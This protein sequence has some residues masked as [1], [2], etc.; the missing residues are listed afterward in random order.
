MIDDP[1]IAPHSSIIWILEYVSS[2]ASQK[3]QCQVCEIGEKQTTS[4]T[5]GFEYSSLYVS[6]TLFAVHSAGCF[7][8]FLAARNKDTTKTCFS[9][10]NLHDRS[11]WD[12]YVMSIY[13]SITTLTTT[14]YGDLHAV[15]TE[16][17]LFNN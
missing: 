6:V 5:L 16:E 7:Y 10:G 3:S 15:A 4:V 2:L 11:I 9:L 13:W 1:N 17:M 12:L 8:N 14:G